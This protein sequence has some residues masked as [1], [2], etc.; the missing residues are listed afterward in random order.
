MFASPALLRPFVATTYTV[1]LATMSVFQQRGL[2]PPRALIPR[3][4]AEPTVSNSFVGGM[5]DTQLPSP[6]AVSQASSK[7]SVASL[8]VRCPASPPNVHPSK[9]RWEPSSIGR[10]Q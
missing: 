6:S 7:E 4:S 1:D 5:E 2:T 9:P 3:I 10:N 8:S